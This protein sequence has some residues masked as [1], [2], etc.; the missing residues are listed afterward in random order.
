MY[1]VYQTS[2]NRLVSS[3]TQEPTSL[4]EGL[5]FIDAG[6]VSFATHEWDPNTL[7]MVPRSATPN[8]KLSVADVL[9]RLTM[10]RLLVVKQIKRNALNAE[11]GD[12]TYA[13]IDTL[14]YFLQSVAVNGAEIDD[15]DYVAGITLLAQVLDGA[16]QLPEGQEAFIEH[17]TAGVE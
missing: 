1:L 15:P 9:R 6:D 5:A 8:T 17:M 3:G 12:L 13:T 11:P 14:E 7:S 16:G 10:P 2:D 4:P